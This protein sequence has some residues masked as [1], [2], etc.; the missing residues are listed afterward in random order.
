MKIGCEGEGD[1]AGRLFLLDILDLDRLVSHKDTLQQE[2]DARKQGAH[3]E[4]DN[5]SAHVRT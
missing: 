5:P 3:E 1:D 4:H 2:R